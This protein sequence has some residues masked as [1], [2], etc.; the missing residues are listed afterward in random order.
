MGWLIALGILTGIVFIPIGLRGI[1]R[2]SDSGVWV[3]LGPAAIRIYPGSGKQ[4]DK[5]KSAETEK[6]KKV[7]GGKNK[8]GGSL[9]D[10]E[11]LLK[12]V[13]T[14]LVE[15]RRKLRVNRLELQLVMAGDD[16]CDLAVNYGRA[17]AAVGTILP[18]L[19][20][21]FVI[22]KRDVAVSCDFTGEST[23][24]YVRLDASITVGRLFV[25]LARHGIRGFNQFKTIKNLRKGG[26]K[27]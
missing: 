20:R 5:Q 17:W 23:R 15:F 24:I 25:L 13:L 1:Y 3:I 16:P 18:Q 4:K 7:S 10:F 27:L 6:D 11:P 2:Q 8:S 26:A 22:K 14:F 21:A 9:R 12:T 19:E